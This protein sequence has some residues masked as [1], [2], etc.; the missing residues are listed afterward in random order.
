M[1]SNNIDKYNEIMQRY[2]L[3]ELGIQ[4]LTLREI[5]SKAGEEDLLDNMSLKELE[6]LREKSSGPTKLLFNELIIKRL[7]ERNEQ[8]KRRIER[9]EKFDKPTKVGTSLNLIAAILCSIGVILQ[10]ANY[11]RE[12]IL[13]TTLLI[14]LSIGNFILFGLNLRYF[15]DKK[16]DDFYNKNSENKNKLILG[17]PGTGKRRSLNQEDV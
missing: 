16:T 10:F 11:N 5:L 4:N 1:K 17:A 8:Q 3:G 13:F 14:I 12:G 9:M 15:K 7:E 2:H 6:Y